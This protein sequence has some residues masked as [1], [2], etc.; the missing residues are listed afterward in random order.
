MIVGFKNTKIW[1]LSYYKLKHVLIR[2]LEG[3]YFLGLKR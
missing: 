2:Q 1:E 3:V